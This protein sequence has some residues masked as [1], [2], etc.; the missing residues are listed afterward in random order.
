MKQAIHTLQHGHS[1]INSVG[2]NHDG[3]RIVSGS[4]DRTVR[5]W[6]VRNGQLMCTFRDPDIPENISHTKS[7]ACV[8]FSPD[9]RLVVSG[10]QDGTVKLWD[11]KTGSFIRIFQGLADR[12]NTSPESLDNLVNSVEFDSGGKRVVV[13]L[14]DKMIK[15]WDICGELILTLI[16][17]TGCVNSARFSPDDS[18]IVS[19]SQ[20]ETIMIW[21]LRMER[22]QKVFNWFKNNLR[23][24]QAVVIARLYENKKLVSEDDL[25]TFDT[26]PKHVR[27]FLIEYLYNS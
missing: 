27:L 23:L 13:A 5:V 14:G 17:H 8:K 3:S 2:F 12:E 22:K 20:D 16:G 19:A 10:S 7:V 24:D 9:G 1:P 15:I 6:N 11:A 21:N 18:K 26:M 25:F 4:D